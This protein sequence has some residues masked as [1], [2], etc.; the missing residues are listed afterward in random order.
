MFT[1]TLGDL[2]GQRDTP[3]ILLLAGVLLLAAAWIGR[4]AFASQARQG[5]RL[6]VL[7]QRLRSE[8]T[9]RRQVEQTL[10]EQGLE[11]PYW[12][13]DPA[14]LHGITARRSYDPYAGRG[15]WPQDGVPL[16]YGDNEHDPQTAEATV[17]RPPV[18]GA[19]P[20]R[21]DGYDRP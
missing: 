8:T 4:R 18:P 21:Y 11:L 9:R 13:D 1:T 16:P 15:P 7:E 6:G 5:R 2:L 3:V 17:M 19:P 14:E 12:P 20:R 10:R